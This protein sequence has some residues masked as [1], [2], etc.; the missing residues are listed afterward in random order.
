L[1]HIQ[2]EKGIKKPQRCGGAEPDTTLK[3]RKA[4]AVLA[5]FTGQFFV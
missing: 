5:M 2:E 3:L 1:F 4:A